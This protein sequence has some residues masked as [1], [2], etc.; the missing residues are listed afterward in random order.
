VQFDVVTDRAHPY[1]DLR[2][3]RR[4][5][6]RVGEQVGEHLGDGVGHGRRRRG[7][8]Q[9]EHEADALLL[10]EWNLGILDRGNRVNVGDLSPVDKTTQISTPGTTDDSIPGVTSSVPGTAPTSIDD[11]GA[12]ERAGVAGHDDGIPGDANDDDG[13]VN[14]VPASPGTGT[15]PPTIDEHGGDV[16]HSGPGRD[17]DGSDDHRG[18][19]GGSDNRGPGGGDDD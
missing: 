13:V 2:R 5:L 4:D 6:D 19:G 17:G 3:G 14:T 9:V 12:D 15:T 1:A 11:H 16:D 8:V 7:S 18:P 10:G